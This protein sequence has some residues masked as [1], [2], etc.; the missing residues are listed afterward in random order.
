[1]V[2]VNVETD[3]V[4]RSESFRELAHELALQI[5]ATSPEYIREEDIPQEVL[6]KEAQIAAAKAKEDG[7]PES[8]IPRIVEGTIEKFKNETVLLRQPYIRNEEITIQ[9]LINEKVVALGE[10]IVVRRF[11]RYALGETTADAE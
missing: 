8:I 10:N 11:E 2:E 4:G 5:A 1:M 6:E 3:F 7:K 9:Q